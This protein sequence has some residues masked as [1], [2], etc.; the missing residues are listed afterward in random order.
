M[1]MDTLKIDNLSFTPFLLEDEIIKRISEVAQ[2]ILDEY[3]YKNPLFLCVL[4]GGFFFAAELL[5]NL[6]FDY[7]I[8][9]V[10]LKSYDGTHSS[11]E[12]KEFYGIDCDISERH[13][14]ILEDI[15]ETGL[16]TNYLI[17]KL[18]DQNPASIIISTLLYK[19]NQLKYPKLPIKHIA[20]EIS[21]A[22]VIGFGL[23]YNGKA[24]NLRD[25]YQ[26][27]E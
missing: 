15:V 9:F 16:T 11:N 22:F 5:R 4:N 21:D 12:I 13:I 10:R 3:Q 2:R 24:R 17:E 20:F 6:S 14:I 19:P 7:E 26:L 1:N 27:V 18:T 23:D 25:I 8:S